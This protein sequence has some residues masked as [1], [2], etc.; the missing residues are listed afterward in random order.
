MFTSGR[1]HD[2]NIKGAFMHMASDA[3]V[4]LGVV[5]AGF[6]MSATGWLWLDPA[7]SVLIGIVIM[8][9]T[10]SVLRESLNLALDAVPENINP[11][12]VEEY[13]KRLSG[14]EAIHDLHIWGMST[15][16]AALTVHLVTP[17]ASID[18]ALLSRINKELHAQF[19]IEHTTVQFEHGDLAHPCS[20]APA[21]VV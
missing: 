10:W 2:L 15:T 16:E 18:D 20:Q 9:G 7:V 19:G 13:L 1:K 12:K 11:A 5:L 6:A 17:D 8:V 3:A 14:V 4:A 21:E